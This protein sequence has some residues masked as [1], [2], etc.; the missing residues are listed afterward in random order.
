MH[1]YRNTLLAGAL[2]VLLTLFLFVITNHWQRTQREILSEAQREAQQFARAKLAAEANAIK[3]AQEAKALLAFETAWDP[4]RR[5]A[6]A[7]DLGNHLRNALATQATRAGLTAEGAT[8]PAEPKVYAVGGTSI[9]V[10][11]VS[12]T[13]SSE[14]LPALLTWLGEVENQFPYA[15]VESLSLSSYASHSVQLGVT[16]YHPIEEGLSMDSDRFK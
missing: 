9:K 11:S 12:V 7:K 8:V 10:Q 6:S 1:Y 4:H 2:I 15:R 5:P 3:A 16:L 14:S 13:V